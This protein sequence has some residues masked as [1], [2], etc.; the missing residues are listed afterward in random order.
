VPFAAV[1]FIIFKFFPES[2]SRILLA[3]VFA[4]LILGMFVAGY[5]FYLIFGL[6]CPVCAAQLPV[7]PE[8]SIVRS[9]TPPRFGSRR[10]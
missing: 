9:A 10:H 5:S 7:G 6:K 8:V 3:G 2:N 4:S 1:L